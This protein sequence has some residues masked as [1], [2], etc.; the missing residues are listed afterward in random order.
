MV[1]KNEVVED[2]WID[3]RMESIVEGMKYLVD[4]WMNVDGWIRRIVKKK[5]KIQNRQQYKK[6]QQKKT[7]PKQDQNK[8]KADGRRMKAIERA[9]K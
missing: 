8:T 2:R 1:R 5:K 9:D 6:K 7:R 3:R 4:K